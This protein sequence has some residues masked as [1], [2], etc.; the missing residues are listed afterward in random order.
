MTLAIWIL[1][2]TCIVYCIRLYL[3][4]I[5]IKTKSQNKIIQKDTL[6]N[7]FRFKLQKLLYE[8]KLQ[9]YYFNGYTIVPIL[10]KNNIVIELM[11]NENNYYVYIN[12]DFS[13]K[14]FIEKDTFNFGKETRELN[15]IIFSTKN[16]EEYI[17]N[18]LYQ[19]K[20]L[21][22]QSIFE[23]LPF[24]IAVEI[25]NKIEDLY[26][27]KQKEEE[28]KKINDEIRMYKQKLNNELKQQMEN[29]K[30]E[31]AFFD[32]RIKDIEKI[33]QLQDFD[34]ELEKGD[35]YD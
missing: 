4:N 2:F 8:K 6:Q 28:Q 29:H 27:E 14:D 31:L 7:L 1:V 21:S 3:N 17:E 33:E 13:I 15:S 26:Y 19:I 10:K 22:E 35:C 24:N 12:K 30:K 11:Y 16:I 25:L 5:E 34:F 23:T 32:K 9:K 20:N 18:N